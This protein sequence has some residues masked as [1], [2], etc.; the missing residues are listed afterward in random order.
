VTLCASALS[1]GKNDLSGD[2][3]QWQHLRQ[4]AELS[5]DAG[6]AIHGATGFI[7]PKGKAALAE[8]SLMPSDPSE[9]IPVMMTPMTRFLKT[10][11]TEVIIMS[12]EGMSGASADGRRLRIRQSRNNA[13]VEAS[14][15][16]VGGAGKE[17]FPLSGFL[18]FDGREI[19]QPF[20]KRSGEADRYVLNDPDR[21]GKVRGEQRQ[22]LL[23]SFR[24]ARRDTDGNNRRRRGS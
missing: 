9:P 15:R 16:D 6:H 17:E 10:C 12:T 1:G 18:H 13:H 5:A 14:R 3:R 2:I 21:N 11:A 19:V 24:A 23:E 8:R 7:L 4:N 22:N 20:R